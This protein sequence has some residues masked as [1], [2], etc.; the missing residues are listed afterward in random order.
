MKFLFYQLFTLLYNLQNFHINTRH[1]T[2]PISTILLS[3]TLE[4]I[5]IQLLVDILK[6]HF[7][8][9]NHVFR[10][11]TLLYLYTFEPKLGFIIYSVDSPTNFLKIFLPIKYLQFKR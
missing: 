6:T 5:E 10:F 11:R 7:R 8:P 1:F 9:Q 4:H 3:E 2:K